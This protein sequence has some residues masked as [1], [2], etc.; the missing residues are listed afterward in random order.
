[1]A[2]YTILPRRKARRDA[3]GI[4]QTKPTSLGFRLKRLR[5]AAAHSLCA[6]GVQFARLRAEK[7]FPR[8][9]CRRGKCFPS[10]LRLRAQTLRGF[11]DRLGSPRGRAVSGAPR[12]P[13]ALPLGELSAK[14]TERVLRGLLIMT[15]GVALCFPLSLACGSPALPEGEPSGLLQ[16]P[17]FPASAC[18]S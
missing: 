5:L 11:F 1:M 15:H 3:Q 4:H 14:L 7:Y 17:V 10:Y 12:V 9:T 6:C 2:Y 8:R 13:L 16:S 18:L